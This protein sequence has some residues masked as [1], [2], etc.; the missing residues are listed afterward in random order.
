[1]T[2]KRDQIEIEEENT[3]V[4]VLSVVFVG[5]MV[6]IVSSY[7][8]IPVEQSQMEL[9]QTNAT[10]SSTQVAQSAK[11]TE[12]SIIKTQFSLPATSIK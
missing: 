5:L 2:N 8:D 7:S 4:R 3:V 6:L 1:M 12:Q 11:Q 9:V 10:Q